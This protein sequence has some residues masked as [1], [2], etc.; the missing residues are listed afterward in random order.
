MNSNNSGSITGFK[1]KAGS[2]RINPTIKRRNFFYYLAAGAAGV[3]AFTRMPFN[4]FKS[5]VAEASKIKVKENPYAVKR[6][7]KGVKNG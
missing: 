4:I 3:Y 6:E 1:N 2:G 7:M 5:K